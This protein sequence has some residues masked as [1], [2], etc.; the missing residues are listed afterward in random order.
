VSSLSGL[1]SNALWIAVAV[2]AAFWL[3]TCVVIVREKTLVTVTR[4][5]SYVRTLS[6]GL[7]FKAPYPIEATDVVLN[8]QVWQIESKIT[9]KSKD[10]AF[11]QIPVKVQIEVIE[12]KAYDAAYSLDNPTEQIRAYV[13]NVVRSTAMTLEVDEIFGNKDT[14]ET[15]V[16]QH[17]LENFRGYGYNVR[18]VLVDDPQLTKEMAESFEKVLR[19]TREQQAATMEAEAIKIRMVGAANAEGESLKIKGEA[20]KGFRKSVAEGNSE[21]MAE[22]LKDSDGSL[23]ARDV[24]A[25]FAGI[26]QR[27]AL[28]DVGARGAKIVFFSGDAPPARLRD[29]VAALEASNGT[30]A[31]N[32]H[33]RQQREPSIDVGV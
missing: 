14:F 21:A 15:A 1:F 24:L 7:R 11:V 8:L 2:F 26:D 27:D 19:A 5:G 3:F 12:D 10:H 25:F 28:R 20:F 31:G 30:D 16:Q 22:F 18:N 4:F 9:A 32:G 6:P 13:E 17:L 29:T 33:A 23:N